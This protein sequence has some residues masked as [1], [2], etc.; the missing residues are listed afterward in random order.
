MATANTRTIM[1]YLLAIALSVG[2][3]GLWSSQD[4]FAADVTNA[5]PQGELAA[6][7]M[8]AQ[9]A[10]SAKP[11]KPSKAQLKRFKKASADF[12]LELFGR[13][14]AAKGKAANVTIA[15]LS[16]MN[17]LAVTANGA[18]GKTA[19][20]MRRV[21]GDGATMS[22]INQ[23]FAWYN[24]RLVNVKKARV[25]T[26]NALWYHNDGALTMKKAFLKKAK[27]YYGAAVKA[28]DF[29]NAQTVDDINGWVA[30]HTNDMIKRIIN[31]LD[32]RDR[33]AIVNALSFDAEWAQPYEKSQV[34]KATFTTAKGKKRTVQM[35]YGTERTYIEGE[36]VTGFVKPYA[37]GYSYVALL[38][39]KGM[40]LKKYVSTLDGDTFRSLVAGARTATV[41][42]AL[43]KYSLS[44]SNDKMADQ[45]AAMG[46]GNAFSSA[47]DFSKMGTDRMGS[48]QLDKVAHKTKIILD[49]KGTK[50]AAATAAMVKANAMYDPD[51]KTVMLDRPFVYAIVDNATKLPVF[52]G[53]VNTIGK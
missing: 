26:A 46:L 2:C 50:A 19:K 15:P 10:N 40:S 14:V 22:V 6:N 43:P 45:L 38:P 37:K 20:Q 27:K 28:A 41:H 36:N 17:V 29:G 3:L 42:T 53:T 13:C 16:V 21:L 24:S 31:R 18:G 12:S 32:A 7:A 51:A 34:H 44:Y 11:S 30:D 33:I 25:R 4:A 49:E 1:T 52:I 35:M 23:N 5:T 47:A 39:A 8:Q 48:L 9:T